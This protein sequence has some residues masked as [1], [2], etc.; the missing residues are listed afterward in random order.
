[1]WYLVLSRQL[2]SS[3]ERGPRLQAHID[4]LETHHRAGRVLFSGPTADRA[5][6]VFIVL[7]GSRQEVE[8]LVAQDPFHAHGD[9]VPEIIEWDAL[10]AMRLD[11]PSVAEVEAMA[12]GGG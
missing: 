10:R 11:G 5:C 12:R 8:A 1:M 4:W 3:A 9:R 6:G 7:A 2:T